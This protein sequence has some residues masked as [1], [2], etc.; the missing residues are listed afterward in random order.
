MTRLRTAALPSP[1]PPTEEQPSPERSHFRRRVRIGRSSACVAPVRSRLGLLR[2]TLLLQLPTPPP[3][4]RG[5]VPACYPR[6]GAVGALCSQ[7]GRG[8][9]SRRVA[10]AMAMDQVNA[11]CEQLVKAVTVMMDPS[12]TQRYRLEALKVAGVWRLGLPGDSSTALWSR[13]RPRGPWT[14]LPN[15]EG[16]SLPLSAP[17]STSSRLCSPRLPL[18][19]DAPVPRCFWRSYLTT[20][21][22]CPLLPLSPLMFAVDRT[23][24]PLHSWPHAFY[25]PK[26]HTPSPSRGARVHPVPSS[27]YIL[28]GLPCPKR[29]P[30]K[31]LS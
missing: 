16:P 4:R 10:V 11:L 28:Y 22:H 2:L 6:K 31:P 29:F 7:D 25:P 5:P 13:R 1:A 24:T 26:P 19:R 21:S 30:A 12:S 3:A 27:S 20:T 17:L 15:S 8:A 18:S 9:L 23:T 14:S